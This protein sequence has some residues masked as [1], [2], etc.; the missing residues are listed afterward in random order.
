MDIFGDIFAQVLPP[1]VFGLIVWL[2]T[3]NERETFTEI[4]SQSAKQIEILVEDRDYW[5]SRAHK[6]ERGEPLEPP[7]PP[8]P[9]P[10]PPLI[11]PG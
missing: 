11:F 4:M 2:M 9:P 10:E 8:V 7:K 3:K 1:G 5:M 6:A